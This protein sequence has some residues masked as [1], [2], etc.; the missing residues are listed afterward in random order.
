[1]FTPSQPIP[2]LPSDTS[3]CGAGTSAA[4]TWIV[5]APAS[6]GGSATYYLCYG[7]VTYQ[8]QFA[9]ALQV[10]TQYGFNG[11]IGDVQGT[12]TLLTEV[13]LPDGTSYGF[14]YDSYLSL[15][16]V[17]LPSGGSISYTWQNEVLNRFIPPSGAPVSRALA[18]RTVNA[19]DGTGPHTWNYQWVYSTSAKQWSHIITDPTKN[20]TIHIISQNDVEDNEVDYY[21]GCSPGNTQF[22]SGTSSLMK[23]VVTVPQG[24]GSCNLDLGAEATSS[25]TAPQT[26]TTYLYPVP[27]GTP[28]V[29]QVVYAYVPGV[30]NHTQY[31]FSDDTYIKGENPPVATPIAGCYGYDQ[32]RS[33]KYYDYGTDGPGPLIKSTTTRYYWENNAAYGNEYNTGNPNVASSELL[34]LVAST[35]IDDG[36]NIWA[37][38]TDYGYDAGT[39]ASS[40]ISDLTHKP[41]PSSV[42]GNLTSTTRLLSK[43]G[44]GPITTAT[45]FDTGMMQTMVDPK[46]YATQ[47]E[48]GDCNGTGLTTVTNTLGQYTTSSYDCA[49]GLM[50]GS[51]DLNRNPSTYSYDQMG[52]ST[53][54]TTS[55]HQSN[56]VVAST[57]TTYPV[58]T[59]GGITT[60]NT[61][62]QVVSDGA[63][64]TT[65]VDG[66]GRT[67]KI[68]VLDSPQSDTTSYSYDADGR[69]QCVSNPQR[70]STDPTKGFTCYQYDAL[71]RKKAQIQ[72]DSSSIFWHFSANTI[73]YCDET[74]RCWKR[75]M[76]GVGRLI[77][78]YE[79][80]GN[81]YQ[82]STIKTDYAYNAMDD[83]TTV[84][85]H[86]ISGET[87]RS[88]SF[89]YDALSRLTLSVNPESG[90]TC[91]GNNVQTSQNGIVQVQCQPDYDNNGNLHS[92]T[93]SRG[94]VTHYIYD[95]L[96]RLTNKSYTNDLANTPAVIY[97][98]DAPF[99]GWNFLPQTLPSWPNTQPQT[100]LIGRLAWTNVGGFG[101]PPVAEAVYGYD[102]M[103]RVT[104]KSTCTPRT[105]GTDHYDMHYTY[106]RAGKV[107]FY[108]RGLDAVR[109]VVYPNSGYYFGG[110]MIH[111]YGA[112]HVQSMT[113]DLSDET[114]PQILYSNP[115]YN[116]PGLVTAAQLGNALIGAWSY[117]NR[118]QPYATTFTNLTTNAV[119]GS[120][121]LTWWPNSSL[122]T[123]NDTV[124]G[125]WSYGYDNV[126]R[127]YTA[128]GSSATYQY[129]YDSFGNR[130]SQSLTA[131]TGSQ[132]S[133]GFTNGNNQ[134]DKGYGVSYDPLGSGDVTGFNDGVTSHTFTY[135]AENR[136]ATVD[137]QISYFYDAEGDRVATFNDSAVTHEYLYDKDHREVTDIGANFLLN[138]GSIYLGAQHLGDYTAGSWVNGG[139]GTQFLWQDQVG[140]LRE[141]FD[142]AGNPVQSC[143]S[144]PFGD[145]LSCSTGDDGSV[146]HFTDKKRDTESN[147]DYFGARYYASTMGRFMSP[148]FNAADDDLDPVPYAN[149]NNPQSLNLYSYVQ[150]NPLSHKDPDG[151][152]CDGGSVGPDGT[153]T[154]HCTNDP[155]PNPSGT[156]YRL[157]GGA[158]MFGEEF[159][160]ADW[161]VVGGL[162]S[163]AYLAAHPIHLSSSNDQNAA[164]QPQ[165]APSQD[166]P[167]KSGPKP[168]PNFVPPTNP[169]Q[170]PPASV[171]DGNNVRVM[172][173]TAQYPNG[174]WVETNSYGQPINPATG[175]PPSNVSRPE[176]RAQ[177]HVPLPPPETNQ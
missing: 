92:K 64:T 143:Q 82:N 19:N 131:G 9:A 108:D 15:Q 158:A 136:I 27:T 121:S 123:S 156:L 129:L 57:A 69:L 134:I 169:P 52:R 25:P 142:Q 106:D 62:L 31:T 45:W 10:A 79:P 128:A 18:S 22:C 177:T 8:T 168:A 63:T 28:S 97:G 44:T 87:A 13:V 21:A 12:A 56:D 164:P 51:T 26:V 107:T 30:G 91:Y 154:F 81:T 16:S 34:D 151:H 88:R 101:V 137:G 23:K 114:H 115:A 77:N 162:V 119:V 89:S 14:T 38:E 96:N 36:L 3:H 120:S 109:N 149:L 152:K 61:I 170:N 94:V 163:A 135:D 140:T 133:Y 157:A 150:N 113:S 86:G 171:P 141:S 126:N 116:A 161:L 4:R 78:V 76:D 127:L 111:Y 20:D 174:Y 35:E 67:S 83:L 176:A 105:C 49:S 153:F 32:M 72:P 167:G 47:Y 122:Q 43:G 125:S 132:N 11:S 75:V 138:R 33:L 71:N 159:G 175:K 54:V 124:N 58:S 39:R 42:Y 60:G 24:S 148:D 147:L 145:G 118:L 166:N 146:K 110:H 99:S 17:T 6:A 112:E 29:S 74:N 155:P 93:D 139:G 90:P 2:G 5:P 40:G 84:I 41:A 50:G 73:T 172:P 98:Y 53:G 66:L 37:A 48:Y 130:K 173:P 95:N 100:N 55:D 46:L 85:Q 103:G 117:S 70:T 144:L 102:A 165:A 160:P 59:S 65:T 80:N 68:A 7:Q 1:V 104:I